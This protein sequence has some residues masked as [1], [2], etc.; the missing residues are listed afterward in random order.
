MSLYVDIKKSLNGF[1]LDVSFEAGKYTTG[2]LGAS[3]CGK[4]MTLK[5]IAGI[6]KPDSGLI[7]LNDKILFDSK[8]N[9]NI[10]PQGRNTGYLFQNYALFP[11]MT[12]LQNISIGLSKH[13]RDKVVMEKIEKFGLS[14]LENRYPHQ[15]SGGQQQRV[16]LAR[17]LAK[18]PDILM[19]DEPF[20]ALDSFLKWQL[21]Q[22]VINVLDGYNGTTLFVSH[23][24]DEVYR[25]C[26]DV[27]IMSNG[28]ID[29]FGD[30]KQIFNKPT[31]VATAMLTGCKNI[32]KAK[33]INETTIEATDWGISFV[34]KPHFDDV[35]FIGVRAHFLKIALQN[36]INSFEVEVMKI[37]ES[38]FA[39]TVM[40]TPKGKS[41]PIYW[42]V[43]KP[44]W[45]L[46]KKTGMPKFLSA[47]PDKI[48]LL[49]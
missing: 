45:E 49:K 24:R 8:K 29:T 26:S 16:A 35:N 40:L 47:Q 42:E 3:G 4:S 39:I 33:K 17:I 2:L 5:C 38:P 1:K 25:I 34:V 41:I 20:S 31:T 30:K 37:I 11:N 32:S 46:V 19:L 15:L 27:A 36:E 23:S 7:M 9:I 21:E 14:G 28:K 22:E 44:Y 13:Q 48:L 18:E 12:T 6:E 10:P 43:E